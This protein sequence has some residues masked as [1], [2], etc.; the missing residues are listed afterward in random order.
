MNMDQAKMWKE[1]RKL[2]YVRQPK[3]SKNNK[4][5]TQQLASDVVLQPQGVM[6]ADL[7]QAAHQQEQEDRQTRA[8]TTHAERQQQ[9]E[10]IHSD[11]GQD[12]SINY[13]NGKGHASISEIP[14]RSA[15][16]IPQ[17]P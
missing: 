12:G 13:S 16:P 10:I 14:A 1:L 5:R 2:F 15:T 17:A 9:L 8:A 3:R 4:S 11:G 7:W 6:R